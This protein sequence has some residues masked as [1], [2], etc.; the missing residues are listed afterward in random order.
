[1]TNNNTVQ[2]TTTALRH[3]RRRKAWHKDAYRYAL[4]IPALIATAVFC[5]LPFVGISIAFKDYDIIKGFAN[6]PWVGIENFR[7]LFSSPDMVRVIWRT[8][9]YSFVI[10][11]ISFPFPIILALMFN[12][13]RGKIFKRTTQTIMYLPHFLSMITVVGMFYSA[14]SVNGPV[15]MLLKNLLGDSYV[16]KNILLE[17]DYFLSVI[18]SVNLWKELGWSSVI[19]MAAIMGVDKSLYESAAID[20][21]GRLAQIWYVTLP[22]IFGTIVIL[23]VMQVGQIFNLSFEL[24]YGFQN[25]YTQNDTDVINT[26]IYRQGIVNGNY[27]VATAFGL[28]QGLVSITLVLIANT[29]SKKWF[30]ISIW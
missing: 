3:N 27:S 14:L 18:F 20:G 9:A 7:V 10:L 1:M 4:L 17:S 24:V 26:L 15:N 23:L 28:A 12:E 11:F 30:S 21:C 8:M 5:Y 13:L 16:P 29:I 6:S 2:L 19:F 25:L 22:G